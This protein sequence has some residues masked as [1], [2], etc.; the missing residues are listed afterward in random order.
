MQ[1]CAIESLRGVIWLGA[2][3][4]IVKMMAEELE[5]E[6]LE[7]LNRQARES[8][9]DVV[10]VDAEVLRGLVQGYLARTDLAQAL[11]EISQIR[12]ARSTWSARQIATRALLK[13]KGIELAMEEEV[14]IGDGS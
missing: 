10:E 2:A 4:A 11:E 12:G 9:G 13:F 14:I 3:N 8:N 6:M 5:I 1:H 7:A